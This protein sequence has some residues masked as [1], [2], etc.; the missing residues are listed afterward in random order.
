MPMMHSLRS[1][2]LSTTTGHVIQFVAKQPTYVPSVAVPE[3]L[4]AGC[5]PVDGET[6]DP[7]DDTTRLRT[8]F[9]TELRRSVLALL[10]ARL[11]KENNTKNFDSA[12]TPKPDVLAK[13][14]H[15]GSVDAKEVREVWRAMRSAEKTGADM[16]LHAD[17]QKVLDILDAESRAELLMVA[18]DHGVAEE[19][20]T[21]LQA[22]D[23]RTKL[24]ARF[25]GATG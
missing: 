21:G 16:G 6:V 24:L 20:V 23:L 9:A 25:A 15:T 19:E 13:M 10:M 1:F 22:R 2:R 14:L 17:A 7:V 8:G 12:G 3:A 18:K 11:A 5:A 4:R